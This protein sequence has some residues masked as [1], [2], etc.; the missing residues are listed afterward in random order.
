MHK[1]EFDLL[2][3]QIQALQAIAEVEAINEML[4]M[5]QVEPAMDYAKTH[6]SRAIKYEFMVQTL[7]A[8][9]GETN[10]EGTRSHGDY[11]S[12]IAEPV[13]HNLSIST[14]RS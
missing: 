9:A 6:A 4:K 13:N 7:R 10:E 1:P 14:R 5:E 11:I 12:V 3:D 8:L 2:I